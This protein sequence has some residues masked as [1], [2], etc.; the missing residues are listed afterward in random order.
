MAEDRPD[1]VIAIYNDHASAFSVELISD[2]LRS[3]RA[4]E[5]SARRRGLGPTRRCRW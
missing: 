5:F 2:L 1:V 3:A 4:A